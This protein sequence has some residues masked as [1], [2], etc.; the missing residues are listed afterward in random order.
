MPVKLVYRP[1]K[2]VKYVQA[3]Q[4][5]VM[6]RSGQV[7]T[8]RKPSYPLVAKQRVVEMITVHRL[9]PTEAFHQIG[10]LQPK[11]PAR[12]ARIWRRELAALPKHTL[13][14]ACSTKGVQWP[15]LLTAVEDIL[16]RN[17]H[18]PVWALRAEVLETDEAK[19]I[20]AQGHAISEA[21]VARYAHRLGYWCSQATRG[22]E[23][24]TAAAEQWRAEVWP[25]LKDS[26]ELHVNVDE[27]YWYWRDVK[28]KELS[29][30]GNKAQ[31][32]DQSL[33]MVFA[34]FSTGRRVAVPVATPSKTH[35]NVTWE[36]LDELHKTEC[37]GTAWV[38]GGA[39]VDFLLTTVIPACEEEGVRTACLLLDNCPA[40]AAN[41]ARLAVATGEW[42]WDETQNPYP[43]VAAKAT[44][45]E[46]A[47]QVMIADKKN[48]EYKK[49]SDVI[50]AKGVALVVGG[51]VL[52]V[53]W[54][55]PNTTAIL[56]PCDL[57]IFGFVKQC[58]RCYGFPDAWAAAK[59]QGDLQIFT[60][61]KASL[62]WATFLRALNKIFKDV[63]AERVKLG[64]RH[65]L[66]E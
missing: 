10:F 30:G 26:Y 6:A 29:K 60:K 59:A 13:P 40:H 16:T 53:A 25:A 9:T 11:D 33:G 61:F 35:Q 31:P 62:P 21:T 2:D 46:E 17:R 52:R 49:Y 34:S 12:L 64:W 54:F 5:R 22:R 32:S 55:P 36:E 51:F 37:R 42:H 45:Y 20:L 65:L 23:V 15:S 39:F 19:T 1:S 58:W 47:I 48:K 14:T 28:G 4:F 44:M 66:G 8:P 18:I 38:S 24:D 56:Q 41:L 7:P 27:S 63:D 50:R 43:F 3:K 57:S